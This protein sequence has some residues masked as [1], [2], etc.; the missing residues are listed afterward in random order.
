[1]KALAKPPDADLR[2]LEAACMRA[3]QF[4]AVCR[5]DELRRMTLDC[6]RFA[7]D[8]A[9]DPAIGALEIAKSRRAQTTHV[10]VKKGAHYSICGLE[11]LMAW[12]AV[13]DKHGIRPGPALPEIAG[14]RLQQGHA[15]DPS[16]RR[17]ALRDMG[18][19]TGISDALSEHS[20]RRGGA[21][22]L[23]FALRI[24]L[25]ALLH[26]HFWEA[27]MELLR[28]IGIEDL[29]SSRALLGFAAWGAWRVF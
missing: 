10:N 1:M 5:S 4:G 15:I 2:K 16:A 13:C 6:L 29:K 21:G 28:C 8:A 18:Q 19:E 3:A 17:K 27:L 11:K 26:M 22:L 9:D 20:A 25:W 14:N 23:Y 12:L 24:D 7:G